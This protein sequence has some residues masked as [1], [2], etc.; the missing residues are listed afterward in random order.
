MRRT[1]L[2]AALVTGVLAGAAGAA[3][4]AQEPAPTPA[5]PTS[6]PPVQPVA[7]DAPRPLGRDA[8]GRYLPGW[9]QYR[10]RGERVAVRIADPG[11]GPD[12]AVSIFDA[13][14]LTVSKPQRTLKGARVI[15]RTRCVQLVRLQGQ[16]LGWVYGD[17][18]FHRVATEDQLLQCTSPK[19]PKPMAR[20]A[21]SIT[22]AD[23]AAPTITHTLLWGLL[24]GATAVTISGTGGADGTAQSSEGVFLRLAGRDARPSVGAQVSGGGEHVRLG[25]RGLS[26]RLTRKLRFPALSG[27][28]VAEAPAPDPAGGPR[29]ALAVA[30]TREGVPCVTGP[31]RV[32]DG[33]AGGVDLRLGLFT[34][35]RLIGESCRPLQTR[36]NAER[37]CDVGTGFGNAEEL[38]LDDSFLKRAREQRR[39]LA[40]RTT[41]WAQCSADVERVTLETPRDVRTLIP[42]AVGHGIL[43]V[44]DGDFVGGGGTLTAH[45]RNGKTWK[46]E[47]MLGG[48]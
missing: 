8:R 31:T 36:P 34:E 5:P 29:W 27:P 44:Y 25:P 20:M 17:G 12:W 45:L 42:S 28:P 15:G 47:L 48:F 23:P 22:I 3:V 26:G 38:E 40:G 4:N 10:K 39:L 30:P 14:R 18:R 24:P 21:S 11:G 7:V 33:R 35:S 37:P 16:D 2:A 13:D 19:R 43:A 46:Q 6:A 41:I 32:V 1:I 9:T